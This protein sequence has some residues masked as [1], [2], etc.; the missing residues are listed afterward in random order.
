[1]IYRLLSINKEAQ[2]EPKKWRVVKKGENCNGFIE[3][4]IAFRDLDVFSIQWMEEDDIATSIDIGEFEHKKT[5][6]LRNQR[7]VNGVEALIEQALVI[8]DLASN[9]TYHGKT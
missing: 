6:R 5:E 8:I 1:M 2:G 9:K 7:I 4:I 3:H